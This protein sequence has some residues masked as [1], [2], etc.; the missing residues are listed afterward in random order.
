MLSRTGT[1]KWILQFSNYNF[2][3]I[4]FVNLFM[5]AM[6]LAYFNAHDFITP[7]TMAADYYA[8]NMKFPPL[9]YYLL[10][11]GSKYFLLL[12]NFINIF[13]SV[14]LS[15]EASYLSKTAQK[16]TVSCLSE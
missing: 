8:S 2:F 7:V 10:F 15:D 12:R 9:S 6:C 14:R 11:R 16:I 13:T 3:N 1:T 4:N 5:H